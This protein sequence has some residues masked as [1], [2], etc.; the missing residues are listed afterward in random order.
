MTDLL[1]CLQG[2]IIF[3]VM[4]L[5][6]KRV[7]KILAAKKLCGV[8]NMRFVEGWADYETCADE[9]QQTTVQDET[10]SYTLVENGTKKWSFTNDRLLCFWKL[11][12]SC[13]IFKTFLKIVFQWRVAWARIRTNLKVKD[14]FGNYLM[15]YIFVSILIL[16]FSNKTDWIHQG[17]N[18]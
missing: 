1:N 15:N 8:H 6:R 12:D 5:C 16:G 10:R 11:C 9:N 13:N 7:W 4:I 17:E 3:V 18:F 14:T 2:V